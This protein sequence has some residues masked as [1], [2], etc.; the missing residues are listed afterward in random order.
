MAAW[1]GNVLLLAL[2]GALMWRVFRR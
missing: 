2:S 1:S